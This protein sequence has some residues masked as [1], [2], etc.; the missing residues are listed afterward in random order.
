[1]KTTAIAAIAIVAVIAVAGAA[2][3]LLS[4][5]SG[6]LNVSVADAPAAGISHLYLTVSDISLQGG[7]N[8]STSFK[9]TATHFDLLT[10]QNVTK[11]IGSNSIPAGNYTMIRFTVVSAIATVSGTNVTLTVPS[12]EV[13]V[14]IRFQVS[15]GKTTSITIDITADMTA[16]SASGNLRP[17]VTVRSVTGP[18]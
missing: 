2:Y 8:S 10:L 11:L 6:T 12:G 13:K 3:I 14:P 15:A 18:S 5:P 16:I 9:V 17:V 4:R 7:G 1:M